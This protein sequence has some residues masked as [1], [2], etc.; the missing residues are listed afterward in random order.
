LSIKPR[1][2]A[3]V[4]S[5]RA[6]ARAVLGDALNGVELTTVDRRFIARLSQWDKRCATIVASLIARARQAGRREALTAEQ[7]GT[8]IDALM[9]AYTYR[10][11]GAASAGCWDCANR[12]IGFCAEHARDAGRANAFAQL[13]AAL[14]ATASPVTAA[15]PDTAPGSAEAPVTVTAPAPGAVPAAAPVTVTVAPAGEVKAAPPARARLD[16]VPGYRRPSAAVAS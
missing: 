9:D 6:T 14:A 1:P 15:A 16:A 5:G 4:D 8:V 3:T 13:A 2:Q 7:L 10:T 11:S 12:A